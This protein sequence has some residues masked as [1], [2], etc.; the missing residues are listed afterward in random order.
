MFC[1]GNDCGPSPN[2]DRSIKIRVRAT[3][4]Y[5]GKGSFTFLFREK[6]HRFKKL[7]RFLDGFFSFNTNTNFHA[8]KENIYKY[9]FSWKT[10]FGV[11]LNGV[12]LFLSLKDIFLHLQRH[13]TITT[14]SPHLPTSFPTVYRHIFDRVF[15]HVL[16]IPPFHMVFPPNFP[17]HN[18][19]E[20]F[21]WKRKT[22]QDC[23]T[24]TAAAPIAITTAPPLIFRCHS[25]SPNLVT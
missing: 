18:F 24:T 2:I 1:S 13:S 8:T 10:E 25:M 20:A 5:Y 3:K 22:W 17:S 16:F 21:L 6:P 4:N 23:A 15:F 19:P 11:L 7:L 9:S 12:T 14:A